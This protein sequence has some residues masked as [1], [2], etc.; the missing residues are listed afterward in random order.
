[1]AYSSNSEEVI[2]R[3]T[4]LD[5]RMVKS[6]EQGLVAGMRKFEGH[7]IRTQLTGRPG[8]K[9]Q[10]GMAAIDWKVTYGWFG[11]RFYAQLSNSPR[12]WYLIVHQ[13][14]ATFTHPGGTS[15]I[16]GVGANGLARF[17]KVRPGSPAERNLPK[18]RPHQITIP[19]RLYIPEAFHKDGR[20]FIMD[21]IVSAF[22][23]KRRLR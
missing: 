22:M 4:I 6:A 11:D 5:E 12:T 19:K 23:S 3:L 20:R 17:V 16:P 14:G 18:T 15:Y 13:K 8:L 2:T 10:T 9:R 21:A 1:M 7:M